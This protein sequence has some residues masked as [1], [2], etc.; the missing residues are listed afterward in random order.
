MRKFKIIINENGNHITDAA[1]NTMTFD[2]D[3]QALAFLKGSDEIRTDFPIY[4]K[5]GAD[6]GYYDS[7][8]DDERGDDPT[9]EFEK[10]YI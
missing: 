10:E 5:D 8:Y 3:Q 1:G 6:D 4:Q 9:C 7:Y 2:S